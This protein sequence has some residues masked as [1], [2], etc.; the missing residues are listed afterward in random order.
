MNY[1]HASDSFVRAF[2]IKMRAWC[3]EQ[4]FE[5]NMAEPVEC[6]L[7]NDWYFKQDNCEEQSFSLYFH[8]GNKPD[9]REKF[10][11]LYKVLVIKFQ[12]HWL[13]QWKYVY[14]PETEDI[15]LV[16]DFCAMPIPHFSLSGSVEHYC[17]TL[18][19]LLQDILHRS[20]RSFVLHLE[21][22]QS[23]I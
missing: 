18:L 11:N 21:S 9:F 8:N 4:D 19:H 12:P 3:Q 1:D 13:I 10:Y 23:S 14:N 20:I 2:N 5:T 17:D 16:N 6:I 7:L 15:R 22:D